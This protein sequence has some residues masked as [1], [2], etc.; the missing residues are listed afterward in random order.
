MIRNHWFTAILAFA[1]LSLA[2]FVAHARG[3]RPAV[4]GHF[5][6]DAESGIAPGTPFSADGWEAVPS[7]RGKVNWTL[8]PVE[9]WAVRLD[10]GCALKTSTT[11][12]KELH[13]V[14]GVNIYGWDGEGAPPVVLSIEDAESGEVY[15][16]S[17]AE[18]S[19]ASVVEMRYPIMALGTRGPGD[20]AVDGDVST[21]W[22]CEVNSPGQCPWI[23]VDLGET[24]TVGGVRLTP[25]AAA[26]GSGVKAFEIFHSR[27]SYNWLPLGAGTFDKPGGQPITVMFEE[28]STER[29][30]KVLCKSSLD[31][32]NKASLAELE[33]LGTDGK[34]LP[35]KPWGPAVQRLYF[36]IHPSVA[37]VI[38]ERQVKL[39]VSNRGSNP[40]VVNDVA[41]LPY[42]ARG[43]HVDAAILGFR[44]SYWSDETCMGVVEV[45]PG[46]SAERAGLRVGDLIMEIKGVPLLPNETR[47]TAGW[48][49]RSHE[50]TL[51]RAVVDALLD[52]NRKVEFT[53]LRGADTLK[54]PISLPDTPA[55]ADTFPFDCSLADAMRRDMV[56]FSASYLEEKG[57]PRSARGVIPSCYSFCNVLGMRDARYAPLL[58]KVA[59]EF[60][61]LSNNRNGIG[62]NAWFNGAAGVML[63][64]YYLATGDEAVLPW[65]TESLAYFPQTADFSKWGH[66]IYGHHPGSLPYGGKSLVAPSI[67]MLTFDA[68]G[69]HRIGVESK[70]WE[71]IGA[72]VMS[73]WSDPEKGG[74]GGQGYGH[75]PSRR[76]S[77]FRTGG[78]G[79]AAKIRGDDR[80]AQ[81]TALYQNDH[82]WAMRDNHAYGAQGAT[83][84]LIGLAAAD[85]EGFR[86][87]MRQYAWHFVLSWE[88][89]FGL[90]Y[91]TY[92]MGCPY[93]D[94]LVIIN[95]GY[96]AVFSAVN[97]GLHMTGASD[98]NWLAVP[99]KTYAREVYITR[100]QTGT[101]SFR[102]HMPAAEIR[103]TLEGAEPTRNSRLYEEPIPL[104][105]GGLVAV[106]AYDEVGEGGPVAR[107]AYGTSR[108]GWTITRRLPKHL[109]NFAFDGD[110]YTYYET[111]RTTQWAR[112]V[113]HHLHLQFPSDVPLLGL[114]IAPRL[115]NVRG[116]AVTECSLR[117]YDTTTK[118]TTTLAE[119]DIPGGGD[120]LLEQP[121]TTRSIVFSVDSTARNWPWSSF[122]ELELISPDPE[123]YYDVER[124]GA[125]MK[126]YEGYPVRYTTDGTVPDVDSA[127]YGG[128]LIE[129]GVGAR[130]IARLVTE[131]GWMGKPAVYE[132]Q[133]LMLLDLKRSYYEH[134]GRVSA[135]EDLTPVETKAVSSVNCEGTRRNGNIALMFTGTVVA[136]ADTQT[137]F[138]VTTH[139]DDVV[140]YV[141]GKAV[142]DNL[143]D[144]KRRPRGGETTVSLKRGNHAF[145]LEHIHGKSKPSL[146]FKMEW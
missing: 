78:A 110:A 111:P 140:L 129:C 99:A 35:G 38:G 82:H 118:T 103:Y 23:V 58:Q 8:L 101:V 13:H 79:L 84:G 123:F 32:G 138:T 136:L 134:A 90:R 141:D 1:S 112:N 142:W 128:E 39:V 139:A 68:L 77:W 133:R 4:N 116:G 17:P 132:P 121:M 2:S 75:S 98:R 72:Y 41:M 106:R 28:P 22:I 95:G 107:E 126:T 61:S 54:V 97:K 71:T 57:V 81:G 109:F 124:M 119:A 19:A 49:M 145:R 59:H 117:R 9:K 44:S 55:F 87:V 53:V 29:Y 31:G 91:S 115:D 96:G 86:S 67:A 18:V 36:A 15:A 122:A 37:N 130:I 108:Q 43:S 27:S 83:W 33:F 85:P 7:G 92:H 21:D 114:R 46:K 20:A 104:P 26:G 34:P 10:A 135:I 137:T 56:A 52:G 76:Q 24:Y 50:S 146:G 105:D 69:A 144:R 120:I 70:T 40:V 60:V 5:A 89:G 73:G 100:D 80:I 65:I 143:D 113:P 74:H 66:A 6:V 30:F 16:A 11:L 48:F 63:S 125:R 51:G 64:E 102:P 93:M 94:P 62:L 12:V 127:L 25:S 131:N 47:P 3:W 45:R 88:P 42:P 14:A